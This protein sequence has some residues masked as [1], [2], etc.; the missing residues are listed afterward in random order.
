MQRYRGRCRALRVRIGAIAGR[1]PQNHNRA[2]IANISHLRSEWPSRILSDL[3]L[4]LAARN[5]PASRR[6]QTA[7]GRLSAPAFSSLRFFF[8]FR[9]LIAP[10]DGM[11]DLR[12]SI[13]FS[14]AADG[15]HRGR[16]LAVVRL[17]HFSVRLVSPAGRLQPGRRPGLP[18][19]LADQAGGTLA[20]LGIAHDLPEPTVPERRVAVVAQLLARG[21]LAGVSDES[22][23]R[24]QESSERPVLSHQPGTVGQAAGQEGEEPRS[25]GYSSGIQVNVLLQLCEIEV[26]LKAYKLQKNS[27][28]HFLLTEI[29]KNIFFSLG[30]YM[31]RV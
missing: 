24:T 11:Y 10:N 19:E 28:R 22:L 18:E 27:S 7:G 1:P 17:Q 23:L 2:L 30:L 26:Y 3:D 5:A 29:L 9:K 13:L 21:V 15:A 16:L 14:D 4:A 12:S 20:A 6:R 8:F 25:F 31:R